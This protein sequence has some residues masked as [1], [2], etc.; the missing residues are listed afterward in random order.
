MKKLAATLA[1][2]LL[3]TGLLAGCGKSTAKVEMNVPAEGDGTITETI[4]YDFQ[5]GM[6]TSFLTGELVP[7]EVAKNRVVTCMINNIDVAMPQSGLSAADI[8]YECVVEGGITRLMGVFQNYKDIP[9][10]GPVRSARHYYVDY[11]NEYDAVY[12]HFG[13]TKYA[14]AEMEA[15]K[16]EELTPLNSA[17][18]VAFYRDN[19]RV[20]PHNAYTDGKRIVKAIKKSKFDKTTS[21]TTPRFDFNVDTEELT[22]E[23]AKQAT[24]V[25]LTYNGYSHPYF[26]YNKK[27]GLYYRYQY[28]TKHIDDQTGKQLTFKNI[29]VQFTNYSNKDKKGY[30]EVDLVGSGKGYYITA[31]KR[32]PITWSKNSKAEYTNYFTEDG[33]ALKVN[34]GKTFISVFPKA[35]KKGV[36]FKDAK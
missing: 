15:L 20:A 10:L 26:V 36:T 33:Q 9:K 6:S 17:G 11:S 16:T 25:N 32:I 13:Q 5:E 12:T 21:L 24:R 19:A 4:N 1:C 23:N 34:P 28:G 31:G 35:D 14:V 7:D 8:M 22:A 30:Q 3:A 27:D 18:A 2:V 29:I